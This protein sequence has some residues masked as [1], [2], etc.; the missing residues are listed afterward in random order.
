MKSQFC[1]NAFRA[2]SKGEQVEKSHEY[3]REKIFESVIRLLFIHR[4][5]VSKLF[6]WQKATPVILSWLAGRT[7]QNVW[8]IN[9]LNYCEICILYIHYTTGRAAGWRPGHMDLTFC[10][11][12]ASVCKWMAQ[13][14][15]I[16]P[17]NS[18]WTAFVT[19]RKCLLRGTNLIFKYNVFLTVHHSIDFFKL[20]T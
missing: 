5:P 6:L 20:P 12:S 2:D 19:A 15:I 17:N 3:T 13:T 8:Y 4:A 10:P 16:S 9:C 18:N 1:R 14:A 11:Q 7:W